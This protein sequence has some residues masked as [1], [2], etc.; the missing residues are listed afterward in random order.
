[1]KSPGRLLST[2]LF[3]LLALTGKATDPHVQ[4]PYTRIDSLIDQK[5]PALRSGRGQL[6]ILPLL[7]IYY[8]ESAV[9]T[10][11]LH[12]RSRDVVHLRR[13]YHYAARAKTILLLSRS[14]PRASLPLLSSVP[15]PNPDK[16]L[17]QKVAELQTTLEKGTDDRHSLLR[18]Y[19]AWQSLLEDYLAA[20]DSGPPTFDQSRDSLLYP[21]GISELQSQLPPDAAIVEYFHEGDTIHAFW[22]FRDNY[23]QIPIINSPALQRAIREF[24][25]QTRDRNRAFSSATAFDLFRQLLAGG[26]AAAGPR[27]S[28][29]CI[30]PDGPLQNL[31]FEALRSTEGP[32]AKWLL[33]DYE[34]SYTYSTGLLF[35]GRLP[36]SSLAYVGFGTGYSAGI[37]SKLNNRRIPFGNAPLPALPLAEQEVRTGSQIFTGICFTG[38]EASLQNF[39]RHSPKARIIHFSLYH[40]PDMEVP[41]NWNILFDDR[42]EPFLL[43]PGNLPVQ[44]LN[45]EFVLLGTVHPAG[46]QPDPGAGMAGINQFFLLSGART[47][48]SGL[49]NTSATS[50]FDITA[51]FLRNLHRGIPGDRALRQAKL[52]YLA[53]AP[54]TGQHPYYW[55][56]TT[57]VGDQMQ[58]P[59]SNSITGIYFRIGIASAVL[60]AILIFIIFRAYQ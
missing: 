33:E 4:I 7:E 22:I 55:S 6:D 24:N 8:R 5:L 30:I 49:W 16:A 18:A 25:A 60:M 21:R 36:S 59:H 35:R 17:R 53:S 31:T 46:H 28:R 45:A 51:A 29:L 1:M 58:A 2:L 40:L 11:G 56:N 20:I 41:T 57:L 54:P 52:A 27:V 48:L 26:L 19:P 47:V 32:S 12:R 42:Q 13:A 3:L 10:L 43:S 38:R 23:L 44:D 14:A 9:N 15:T 39:Y 37:T 50:S 34:L